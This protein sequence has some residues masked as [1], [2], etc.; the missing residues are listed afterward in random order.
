MRSIGRA[1]RP[2]L[3]A[4]HH[5]L[6]IGGL[7]GELRSPEEATCI[8][9]LGLEYCRAPQRRADP[10]RDAPRCSGGRKSHKPNLRKHPQVVAIEKRFY[11]HYD[12]FTESLEALYERSCMHVSTPPNTLHVPPIPSNPPALILTL[13]PNRS[14]GPEVGELTYAASKRFVWWQGRLCTLGRTAM[15]LAN[16]RPRTWLVMHVYVLP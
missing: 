9:A 12:V 2:G 1:P 13:C 5:T 7:C 11:T 4:P 6:T 15:D 10:S 3:R 14:N 8:H 16:F